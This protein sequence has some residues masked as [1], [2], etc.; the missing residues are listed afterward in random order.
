MDVKKIAGQAC[1]TLPTVK[2]HLEIL[3]DA[4]CV[5]EEDGVYIVNWAGYEQAA[6]DEREF[7]DSYRRG[8]IRSLERTVGFYARVMGSLGQRT[9]ALSQRRLTQCRK[10]YDFAVS[11]LERLSDGEPVWAV[12]S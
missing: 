8:I 4:G 6:R 3:T 2:R 12:L 1:K 10:R 11:R 9:S 7:S 5:T